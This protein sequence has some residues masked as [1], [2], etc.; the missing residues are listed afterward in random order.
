MTNTQATKTESN[1]GSSLSRRDKPFLPPPF[2][3]TA[4]F[5]AV[6][7]IAVSVFSTAQW[8]NTTTIIVIVLDFMVFVG[9]MVARLVMAWLE[10]GTP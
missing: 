4:L 10:R 3:A 5:I 1:G 8:L 9:A 7:A 6:A 2:I